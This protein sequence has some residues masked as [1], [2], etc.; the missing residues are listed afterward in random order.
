MCPEKRRQFFQ[1]TV[2]WYYYG[3]I[4]GV[5][6][7]NCLLARRVATLVTGDT[8]FLKNLIGKEQQQQAFPFMYTSTGNQKP[9]NS[10][11]ESIF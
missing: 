4:L 5:Q 1:S 2:S 7:M 10:N 3:T 9:P 6:L 11:P 8:P